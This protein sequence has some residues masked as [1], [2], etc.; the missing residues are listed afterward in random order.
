MWY[1]SP[2]MTYDD[3]QKISMTVPLLSSQRS[4]TGV[5]R[6]MNL[7]RRISASRGSS[8]AICSMMALRWVS[9]SLTSD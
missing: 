6:P 5:A 4:N 9:R 2:E 7:Q 3:G 1:S 8:G